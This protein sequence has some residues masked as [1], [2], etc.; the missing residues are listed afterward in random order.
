[1]HLSM[2]WVEQGRYRSDCGGDD[3]SA[4]VATRFDKL[5]INYRGTIVL[6]YCHVNRR[7]SVASLHGAPEPN[8]TLSAAS[9]FLPSLPGEAESSKLD[10]Y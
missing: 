8:A 4:R 1:M 9:G 7:Y 5:A 10:A 2:G 3:P 6:A